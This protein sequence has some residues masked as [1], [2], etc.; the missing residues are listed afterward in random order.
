MTTEDSIQSR[1]LNLHESIEKACYSCDRNP[2]E[3][4]LMCVSKKASTNQILE[5]IQCGETLFGENYVQDAIPKIQDLRATLASSSLQTFPSFCF[6]GHLQKNKV[7]KTLPYFHRIDSLDS[8]KL[9]DTVIN[10]LESKKK[11]D[12]PFPTPYPL[13]IE[14]KTSTDDTKYGILPQKVP[15]FIKSIAK[16]KTIQVQGFMTMATLTNEE[17]EI[18]R[19]FALLRT[20]KENMEHQFNNS[21]PVL[22]MGMTQDYPYA[23]QEGS[24]LLRIGSAIFGGLNESNL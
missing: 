2:S 10:E 13:L 14:V 24:T 6:I 20:L 1:L 15:F 4:S 9:A 21:F 18:R 3:V 11:E 22:S 8:P 23:I 17:I 5:A 12:A 19:C 7:R 16:Y